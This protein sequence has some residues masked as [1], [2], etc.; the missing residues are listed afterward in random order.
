M[1]MQLEIQRKESTT[2]LQ[3]LERE[4]K[5]FKVCVKETPR[6]LF[7]LLPRN[8][9]LEKSQHAKFF[10]KLSAVQLKKY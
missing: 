3:E 8:K 5:L 10:L 9:F 2:H 1:H 6:A 4:N 7:S